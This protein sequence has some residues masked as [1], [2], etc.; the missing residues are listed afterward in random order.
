ML[1]SI[2]FYVKLF[3]IF[4]PE[5]DTIG[6]SKQTQ[7]HTPTN[8]TIICLSVKFKLE[9]YFRNVLISHIGDFVFHF[10]H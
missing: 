6:H 5:E 2:F 10:A 3:E 4:S 9:A 8:L 7:Y 1:E